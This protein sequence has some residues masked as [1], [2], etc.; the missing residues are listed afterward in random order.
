M[1]FN[2]VILPVINM[3]RPISPR[4]TRLT[5]FVAMQVQHFLK[6]STNSIFFLTHVLTLSATDKNHNKNPAF[7]K[8]HI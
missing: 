5:I 7:D 8:N 6:S 3:D 2:V 1:G 4:F